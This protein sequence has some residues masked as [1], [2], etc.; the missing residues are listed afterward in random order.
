MTNYES[1]S[2]DNQMKSEAIANLERL[3]DEEYYTSLERNNTYYIT[4]PYQI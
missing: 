2:D 4:V 3:F 1:D